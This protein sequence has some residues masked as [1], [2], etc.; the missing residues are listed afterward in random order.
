MGGRRLVRPMWAANWVAVSEV[1]P[2]IAHLRSAHVRS[3]RSVSLRFQ[4]H[5][6]PSR[7]KPNITLYMIDQLRS[8]EPRRPSRPYHFPIILAYNAFMWLHVSSKL[9]FPP[10]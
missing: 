4:R 6:L 7:T 2:Q 5:R 10:G 8:L 1:P 9:S 3:D